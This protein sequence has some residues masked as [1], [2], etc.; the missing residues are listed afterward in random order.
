MKKTLATLL[1]VALVASLCGVMFV[2][3]EETNIA[4][5]KTVLNAGDRGSY[6]ADLTDGNAIDSLTY[7]A[8]DW[9]GFYWNPGMDLAGNE[10][11]KTNAI[12]GIALPTVDLE[13]VTSIGTVRVNIFDGCTSGITT[14][15]SITLKVSTDNE[16]Y[17]DVAVKS[18]EWPAEG[19]SATQWVEFVLET[20]VDARYVQLEMKMRT[21]FVFINEI[22]VYE[23]AAASEPSEPVAEEHVITISHVNCYTWGLYNEMIITGEGQNAPSKLGYDCTWWIAL[24]VDKVDGVLTVTQIEGNGSAKEMTASADGFIVYCYSNDAAS[25]AAAQAI[26]IGDVLLNSTVD[27]SAD[28]ASE[29]AI[30]TLTFGPAVENDKPVA[31]VVKET[32]KIDGKLND[33]GYDKAEWFADG[34]WQS[35]KETDPVIADLD[36]QYTV[37]SDDDNIYLTIKVNQGVDFAAAL[38]PNAAFTQV[39]AT[40]FRLWFL[41]DGMETRTFYDL[42]WDGEAF[43]PFREKVATEELTFAAETG[44]DY[45]NLE[46]AIAKSSLKITDSFKLMVTYSTPNCVKPDGTTAYNAFHMTACDEM[47]SGWSGNADAYETYACADIA[48]GTKAPAT[49][50]EGI[51]VFALLGLVAIAGAAITIKSKI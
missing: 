14:P 46:I 11:N 34:L 15:E 7:N 51:L 19:A 23:A 20:P 48:L 16:T 31:P 33:D 30:G 26:E 40:D 50:D 12:D 36:V 13:E 9:F 45:I 22:E 28:A 5:G 38:D 43:V 2:S 47:P 1:V 17:T 39:G 3:A 18:F 25:F 32:I 29:T 10:A 44:D 49:G 6:N 21:T 42:L 8:E 41:G 4:L 37:R 35:N 27:W 24:K